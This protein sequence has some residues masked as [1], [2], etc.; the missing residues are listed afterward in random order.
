MRSRLQNRSKRLESTQGHLASRLG[1]E[2]GIRRHAGRL[3][4]HVPGVVV[5]TAYFGPGT[6]VN[7]VFGGLIAVGC[8]YAIVALRGRDPKVAVGDLSVLVTSTLLCIALPP[9]APGG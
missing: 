4:G 3:A 9:Y 7:I 1:T 8:E 6:L 2:P 5:L